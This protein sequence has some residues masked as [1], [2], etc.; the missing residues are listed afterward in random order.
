MKK[1]YVIIAGIAAALILLCTIGGI[2]LFSE[3][4]PVYD[5]IPPSVV[6]P[7]V[8]IIDSN[9]VRLKVGHTNDE[10]LETGQEVILHYNTDDKVQVG[11][12]IKA[13]Y[14][15][16][17]TRND[18]IYI[19]VDTALDVYDNIVAYNEYIDQYLPEWKIAEE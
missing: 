5:Y 8:E 11:N 13:S 6:G 16:I 12:V 1:K 2:L 18:Y 4:E 15:G 3:P 19:G 7:V 10:Q 17:E 14:G 9:T